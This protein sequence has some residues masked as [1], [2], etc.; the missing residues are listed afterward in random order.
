MKLYPYPGQE[1]RRVAEGQAQGRGDK[2]RI[3]LNVYLDPEDVE[4]IQTMAKD[5]NRTVSVHLREI[6]HKAL[7]P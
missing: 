1:K 6:I 7:W 3:R 5:D 2:S 4:K